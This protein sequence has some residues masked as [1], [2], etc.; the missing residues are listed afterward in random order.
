MS[1]AVAIERWRTALG[2]DALEAPAPF[3]NTHATFALSPKCAC[4][5]RVRRAEQLASVVSVAAEEG[6]TLYPVSRGQ[7]VGY[8][9]ACPTADADAVLDLAGFSEIEAIDEDLGTMT[10]GVGVTQREAAERLRGTPWMISATTGPL[11]ASVVANVLERGH[12]LG[13]DPDHTDMLLDADV[14]VP[15]L[16]TS[17]ATGY[18]RLSSAARLPDGLPP[19]PAVHGL[20]QQ[21]AYGIVHRATI[22]LLLRPELVGFVFAPCADL[23]EVYRLLPILRR[24]RLDGTLRQGPTLD[25]GLRTLQQRTHVDEIG[26]VTPETYAEVLRATRTAPWRI[27]FAVTGTRANVEHTLRVVETEL[28]PA[29]KDMTTIGFGRPPRTEHEDRMLRLLQGEPSGLGMVRTYFAKKGKRADLL[30]MRPEADRCGFMWSTATFPFD[31]A[32]LRTFLEDLRAVQERAGVLF[33]VA[34]SAIR[35][36][37]LAAHVSL[38]YDRDDASADETMEGAMNAFRTAA[39]A[40]G[41]MPYRIGVHPSDRLEATAEWAALSARLRRALDPAG[42]LVGRYEPHPASPSGWPAHD[43]GVP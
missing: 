9:G 3:R 33:D 22:R 28:R 13:A 41:F 26:P 20:F 31:V 38:V 39:R 5:V 21:A 12:G 15:A 2:A 1:I 18:G 8:G 11:D 35:P 27:S 23:E 6:V 14:F 16:G 32:S 24:L 34:I 29:C 42:V 19:G 25:N 7:N 43:G 17:V 4:V 37:A 30:A 40:R 36:R 10:L